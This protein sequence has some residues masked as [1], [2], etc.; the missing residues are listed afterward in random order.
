MFYLYFIFLK[1]EIQRLGRLVRGSHLLVDAD[2]LLVLLQLGAVRPHLQQ[3]LV[4]RTGGGGEK[5]N[6]GYLKIGCMQIKNLS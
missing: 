5:K 3:T 6:I 4:G 1:H 2:G